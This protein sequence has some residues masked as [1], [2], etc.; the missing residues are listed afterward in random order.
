MPFLPQNAPCSVLK[1]PQHLSSCSHAAAGTHPL[2]M[3][4][5]L[6]TQGP[7][8]N[9]NLPRSP[10]KHPEQDR[11]LPV[12]TWAGRAGSSGTKCIPLAVV[13]RLWST[14]AVSAVLW[15]PVLPS[16]AAPSP[17]VD[18]TSPDPLEKVF[19]CP[20]QMLPGEA[21]R[22]EAVRQR[23]SHFVLGQIP[24]TS[25]CMTRRGQ[26]SALLFLDCIDG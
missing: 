14:P 11:Q 22:T 9:T 1:E 5:K 16:K 2:R 21:G 3:P 7:E 26:S 18:S 20:H 24:E 10:K 15:P 6:Q 12:M 23:G 4:D 25:G 13:P 19:F 8:S 17:W